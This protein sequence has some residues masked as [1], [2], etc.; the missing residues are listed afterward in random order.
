MQQY[1]YVADGEEEEKKEEPK[2]LT[3]RDRRRGK[4]LPQTTAGTKL[5][6]LKRKTKIKCFI[7]PLL[8]ANRNA[9]NVREKEQQRREQMKQ[10]SDKEKERN[11]MLQAKQK[12]EKELDKEKKKT[13]KGERRRM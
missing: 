3:P 13:Q 9:A 7:D 8:E 6:L 12:K 1:G 5:D 11:R 2:E 10:A 4:T